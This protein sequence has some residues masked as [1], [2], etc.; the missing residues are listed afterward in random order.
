MDRRAA[1]FKYR[2]ASLLKLDQWEG[3]VL[4]AELGRARSLVDERRKQLR[5]LQ[6]RIEQAEAAM[7]DL[8]QADAT[9]PYERRR[10][11]AAYLK[12][13]Y[14]ALMVRRVDLAQAEQ[15]FAQILAQR[16][17]K[18]HKIKAMEHQ[19][20]RERSSHDSEQIRAGLRDADELW[21]IRRR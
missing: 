2:L 15:L 9:I 20:D 5:E 1:P 13:Q 4:G 8:H 12:E 17:A 16:Q 21:L 18:Q 7:R 6:E 11:L 3:R 14:A 19:R 10:L